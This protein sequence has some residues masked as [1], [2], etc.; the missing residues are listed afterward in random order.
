MGV[1]ASNKK[2]STLFLGETFDGIS[3]RRARNRG[4]VGAQVAFEPRHVGPAGLSQ[5]P[6]HGLLNQIFL[7]PAQPPRVFV[8]QLERASAPLASRATCRGV[9]VNLTRAF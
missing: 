5:R 7:V 3:E 4:A 1:P 2:R 9:D 8:Q 6:A